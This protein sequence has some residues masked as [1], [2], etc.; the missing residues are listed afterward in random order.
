MWS[1][2]IRSWISFRRMACKISVRSASGSV[3]PPPSQEKS[4]ISGAWLAKVQGRVR[5]GASVKVQRLDHFAVQCNLRG[6]HLLLLI[7]GPMGTLD[8]GGA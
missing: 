7:N 6:E 5:L 1:V 8:R 3:W 2:R 4:G